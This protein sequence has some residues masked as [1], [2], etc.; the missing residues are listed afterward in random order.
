MSIKKGRLRS[1]GL[2]A[3]PVQFPPGTVVSF[4]GNT[5]PDG[6]LLCNG[7]AINRTE[8]SA[9]FAAIGTVHGAGDGSTTFN[10]PNTQG[11]VPRGVGSQSFSGR[12]KSGG[13]LGQKLEDNMQRIT[14]T[15]ENRGRNAGSPNNNVIREVL[16]S[17][18]SHTNTD[19]T[20]ASVEAS[21]TSRNTMIVSFNSAASPNARASSDT[22]GETRPSSIAFNFIIKV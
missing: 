15:F 16:G 9:L 6:W 11:L 10:L 14:G 8:Y 4:A 13:T 18:N 20:I 21:S 7:S 12:P 5:A 3:T 19:N 17:F 22:S 2:L 1:S